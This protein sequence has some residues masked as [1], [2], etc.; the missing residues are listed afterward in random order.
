MNECVCVKLYMFF[1]CV[2]ACAHVVVSRF[3]LD[4]QFNAQCTRVCGGDTYSQGGDTAL[5]PQYELNYMIL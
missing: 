4:V 3:L 2:H 5:T 1:L